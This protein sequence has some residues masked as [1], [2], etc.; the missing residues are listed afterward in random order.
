MHEAL[1]A[2]DRVVPTEELLRSRLEEAGCVDV[3]SF[4]LRIPVGPWA[5]DKYEP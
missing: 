1:I 5:K 2:S 3:Q 4:T